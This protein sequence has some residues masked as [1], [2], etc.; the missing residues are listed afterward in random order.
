VE[1]EETAAASPAPASLEKPPKSTWLLAAVEKTALVKVVQCFLMEAEKTC[2][3][4]KERLTNSETFSM[5]I[6][7]HKKLESSDHSGF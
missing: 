4:I 1:A 3:A 2:A 5:S 6:R 7:R